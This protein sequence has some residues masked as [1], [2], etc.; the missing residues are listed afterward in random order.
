MNLYQ[1][2]ITG[3][4]KISGSVEITGSLI[5]SAV[6]ASYATNLTVSGTITAQTLV[7]Q[8]VTSSVSVITGSTNFGT[9]SSNNHNFTGSVNVSGSLTVAS[10]STATP[11]F[12]VAGGLVG[13]G[14]NPVYKL[15]VGDAIRGLDILAGGNT[16]A[17][18]GTIRARTS[19][20]S[21]T[22]L[23]HSNG[24]SYLLGGNVG[25][26][27]SSPSSYGNLTVLMP[28][29][30]NGTGI[31]IKAR[32]DGGTASQPALTYLNG[33]GNYIAQIVADNG[34]GY[35]AF[36]TGTSNT[37]RMR[38]TSG[39]QV[40]VDRSSNPAGSIM[41]LSNS[42]VTIYGT[43]GQYRQLNQ[44][45]A[46]LGFFN[47]S[48]EATLTS[49]GV[50]TNA[51]DITIKKDIKDIE[52]GLS[53]VLELK[54]KWY[55]MIEDDLEQ[56]GFIAQDVEQIIPEVVSTSE[57]GM[58]NL[59]YSQLTAVLAKAIQELKADNDAIRAELAALKS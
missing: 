44:S 52:Y 7:V 56:I 49:A 8:T 40:W 4:L 39:G 19:A 38:I 2:T 45:G 55:R 5:G 12:T 28:D 23:L 41:A 21:T 25:I 30:S 37:E 43:T 15:D 59:S 24:T 6:T 34:T 53:E 48:N 32:N 27:T 35:L 36:N 10:G 46:V 54:P 20:N 57:R 50:W 33:S 17:Y 42:G 22:V 51:S 11:L 3:S 1:P 26:G 47:G 16:F 14:M 31:V 29:A 9:L 13:I 58:K 18:D